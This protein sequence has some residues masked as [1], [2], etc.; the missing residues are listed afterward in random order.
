VSL[1]AGA[2]SL[3]FETAGFGTATAVSSD[4]RMREIGGKT[5]RLVFTSP[6]S[7]FLLDFF[8]SISDTLW[9]SWRGAGAVRAEAVAAGGS[10]T[11]G[12]PGALAAAGVGSTSFF[13]GF[14]GILELDA[15]AGL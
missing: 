7:D 8:L 13:R 4:A 10:V 11:R 9:F 5:A 2:D 12:L 15:V 14:F 1:V 6:S 3:S